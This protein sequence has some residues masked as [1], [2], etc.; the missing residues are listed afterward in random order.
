ML[1]SARRSSSEPASAGPAPTR[2]SPAPA[3]GP[4]W[5]SL[6]LRID[7]ED[8]PLEREA[9]AFGHAAI[10]SGPL[11]PGGTD[12][13]PPPVQQQ[14]AVQ[15]AR[16]SGDS[17]VSS[18]RI[19]NLAFKGVSGASG[20]L[21]HGDQIQASF[22]AAHD[23][24][25]VRAHVG[26]SAAEA[27]TGMNAIAFTA[28]RDVAFES[29][30]DVRLAAHEAT[31][32]V[33]QRKGISLQGGVGQMD[34]PYERHA[35]A[36]AERVVAGQSSAGLLAPFQSA[37][38]TAPVVQQKEA[39]DESLAQKIQRLIAD[40]DNRGIVALTNAELAASTAEQ[41][42][43][44]VRILAD[45]AWTS[46][47]DER[48]MLRLIRCSGQHVQ[49]LNTLTAIGYRRL[50]LDSVDNDALHQELETLLGD[51]Q[52]PATAG[53]DAISR[54]LASRQPSDVMAITDFSKATTA[55]RLGLLQILLNM[56]SSNAAE[57]AKILDIL[58][59]S[60]I[61]LGE[62]MSKLRDLGL[63][64]SLFDHIDEDANKLRLT[65]LL[66]QLN[67]P[68]LTA[69]L[70]VFNR[71]AV[72]NVLYAI[73]GGFVSAWQ[74]FSLVGMVMGLLRPILQ[75]I[76]TLLHLVDEAAVAIKRPTWDTI[77]TALRDIAGALAVWCLALS[78]ISLGLGALAFGLALLLTETVAPALFLAG[79]AAW[80]VTV[81]EFFFAGSQ[82][83]GIAFLVLA[84][85]KL[86]GDI[87]QGGASTTAR[88]LEREQEQIGEGI[89]IGVVVFI[90]WLLTKLVGRVANRFRRSTTDPDEIDPDKLREGSKKVEE[91]EAEAKKQADDMQKAADDVQKAANDAKQ[92]ELKKESAQTE[93]KPPAPTEDK[94]PAPPEEKRPAP[95]ES[96]GRASKVEP[97]EKELER[98][99]LEPRAT[100]EG[101]QARNQLARDIKRRMPGDPKR[102]K[103]EIKRIERTEA[104][105]GQIEAV[106]PE[107]TGVAMEDEFVITLE[108]GTK[109]NADGF[110][111]LSSNPKKYLL[112]EHKEV[113]TVWERS[114]FA[115][116]VAV[117]ELDLMLN[118]HADIFLKLEKSGCAG[119]QYSTNSAEL[120][121]LLAERI[122]L[123]RRSGVRGLIAPP[124]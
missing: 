32:V 24:S 111:T 5:P 43:G 48:A 15:R 36:V 22:G 42:V 46:E 4:L 114:H 19:H 116:D 86:I 113:L 83:F 35:D 29:D 20:P 6:A 91:E 45:Q 31:H 79:V 59:S 26:G 119:F 47:N 63:K 124:L 56:W 60:G 70:E 66:Q 21:P 38:R 61:E 9:D 55:Q 12:G 94:Q 77:L 105:R 69:D 13:P 51:A 102:V 115:R 99:K 41:R 68:A 3:S 96:R 58:P 18:Q 16:N 10:S 107:G 67:D 39:T 64:Q 110:Q 37:T 62:L 82:I 108:D 121:N 73:G 81:F 76:D 14:G 104:G 93:E 23:L 112:L 65:N 1:A 27:A 95:A 120:A 34:D 85:V 88:E 30:P 33:Q 17:H 49:V 123:M 117:H 11:S 80:L 78:V 52:A 103:V 74:K 122:A 25:D 54:A 8:S 40:N 89:T 109:F 98:K 28:G 2:A 72:W 7:P 50:L 106:T 75:P 44:M 97:Y 57:E 71:G 92:E 84:A 53:N 100:A 101:E 87:V 118:R 90:A